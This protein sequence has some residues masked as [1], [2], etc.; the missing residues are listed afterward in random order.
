VIENSSETVV[1]NFAL[2][3]FTESIAAAA[4]NKTVYAAVRNATVLGQV[5]GLIEIVDITTTTGAPAG[6]IQ[7]P[8]VRRIVLSH[9]GSKLL[10]FSDNSNQVAVID[11]ASKAVVYVSGFDHPVSAVFSSDDATAYVLSCGKE[12]GGTTSKVNTLTLSNNA[13]GTDV[14][15]S[16]ATTALLDSGNLYVAGNNLGNGKLDI[17]ATGSMTVSKSGVSIANGYHSIMAMAASGRLFIGSTGCDNLTSGCLS[18]YN[19]GT[20]AVTNSKAGSGDTTGV[21]PIDGRSVVYV[22]QGFELVIWDTATDA[23]LPAAKQIDIV[24]QAFDV[25]LID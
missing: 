3:D 21:Q 1:A 13:V 9:N 16:G 18:I 17:I 15:V 4:D 19:T 6:S 8:A 10:A 12:C 25:K 11:T 22:V 23:P 20:S 24:G 2:P 7:V 14:L 5:S